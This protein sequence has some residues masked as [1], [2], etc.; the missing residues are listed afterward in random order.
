MN[1]K[2][3]NDIVQF[4]TEH[5]G[6]DDDRRARVERALYGCRVLEQINWG[7]TTSTFAVNLVTTLVNFGE[8]EPGTPALITLLESLKSQ[9]GFNKQEAFN[10]LIAEITA[11]KPQ[12]TPTQ[13]VIAASEPPKTVTQET[14]PPLPTSTPQ[15]TEPKKRWWQRLGKIQIGTL[16]GLLLAFAALYPE[17]TRAE[18]FRALGLLPQASE[19]PIGAST[20]IQTLEPSATTEPTDT[21]TSTFTDTPT[22]LAP[23]AA[24]TTMPTLE[25]DVALT[26]AAALPPTTARVQP[27][28]LPTDTLS[29][30]AAQSSSVN[31]LLSRE[32]NI[33]VVYIPQNPVAGLENVAF[34]YTSGSNTR[35]TLPLGRYPS[36]GLDFAALTQPT[37]FVFRVQGDNTP[38]P[39]DCQSSGTLVFTQSLS[40][41]DVFWRDGFGQSLTL[42]VMQGETQI[43]L[44]GA[45]NASCEVNIGEA[46][47]ASG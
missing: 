47:A 11:E 1:P 10:R 18:V 23:T 38:L 42:L 45:G 34:R 30:A 29:I 40:N 17:Q 16:I 39:M 21:F 37:C 3:F 6:K 46:A 4:L 12:Q 22:L 2:L 14:S 20:N 33:F 36:F 15:P 19:T 41:A 9:V 32:Q 35:T 43:G 31:L 26:F 44:C 24:P 5:L 28:S 7:G 13:P 8:C 27:T 25:P